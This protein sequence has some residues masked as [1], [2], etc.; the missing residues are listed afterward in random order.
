MADTQ[1]SSSLGKGSNP[2]PA[3]KQHG[4][5]KPLVDP[6]GL[7]SRVSKIGSIDQIQNNQKAE[8]DQIEFKYKSGHCGGH[9]KAI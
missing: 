7:F 8:P 5:P 4:V 2:P 9:A 1:P 3:G 6:R